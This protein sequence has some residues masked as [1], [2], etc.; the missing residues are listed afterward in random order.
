M[1]RKSYTV[2]IVWQK[3]ARVKKFVLSPLALKMAAIVLGIP[4]FISLFIIF[5]Q[6]IYV[7]KVAGLQELREE[8]YSRQEEL[9]FLFEKITLF[10]EQLKKLKEMEKQAE[11]DLKEI[12]E[13]RNIKKGSPV[14]PRKKISNTTNEDGKEAASFR[15]EEICILKK[16]RSR[17]V[18]CLHQDLLML[19]KEAFQ[20][21]QNLEELQEFLK[22]QKSILLSTPS[23][24]PVFGPITSGFGDTRL[25]SP[26][27]GTRPHLGVDIY[28]LPGTA[29]VAGADGVVSFA[30]EG[31]EYG[32]VIRINHGHGFSTIYGHLKELS[33][34]SGDKVGM[35]QVI[36]TVGTSGNSTGAHLHYEVR[37]EGEPVNPVPYLNQAS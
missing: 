8:T 17:L 27:G 11:S 2:L 30:G 6:V 35:G 21:E 25:S 16:E 24:W 4:I 26:S 13:L 9:R 32:L 29:V 14:I 19:R 20:R 15:E 18:S 28:A 31:Q 37:I 7:E 3:A 23:L 34:Q 10:E 1:A 36:G 12:S 22:A 33:V 5:D